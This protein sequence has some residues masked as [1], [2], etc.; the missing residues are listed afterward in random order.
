MWAEAVR[1]EIWEV[2][3]AEKNEERR[4]QGGK[5]EEDWQVST[6]LPGHY[7]MRPRQLMTCLMYPTA[8]LCGPPRPTSSSSVNPLPQTQT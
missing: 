8:Y 2:L 3:L 6:V 5:A 1:P 7:L 4:E